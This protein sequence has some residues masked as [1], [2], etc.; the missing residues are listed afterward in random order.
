[1]REAS[2]LTGLWQQGSLRLA[3]LVSRNICLDAGPENLRLIAICRRE[4]VGWLYVFA[5]AGFW[6]LFRLTC[7][8][9]SNHSLVMTFNIIQVSAYS[10]RNINVPLHFNEFSHECHTGIRII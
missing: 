3:E 4:S 9:L 10:G 8:L 1:M 6:R 5:W 7:A 2:P